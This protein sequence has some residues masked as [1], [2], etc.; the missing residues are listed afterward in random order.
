[1]EINIEYRWA[2]KGFNSIALSTHSKVYDWDLISKDLQIE[3]WQSGISFHLKLYPTANL[4]AKLVS[5]SLPSGRFILSGEP[6]MKSWSWWSDHFHSYAE[7]H[8]CRKWP[9]TAESDFLG[10]VPSGQTSPSY[11]GSRSFV[12][13][14]GA[15]WTDMLSGDE[16]SVFK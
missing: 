7:R 8:H 10:M 11:F 4:I 13:R 3:T 16:G 5:G 2:E 6:M 14:R 9:Q 15:V 1:M 12:T